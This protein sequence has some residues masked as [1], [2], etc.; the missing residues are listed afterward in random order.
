[1]A[2]DNVQNYGNHIR[3]DPIF[4]YVLAPGLLIA[5]ICGVVG[6]I[7]NPSWTGV[8]LL[9]LNV[10]AMGHFL[11]TRIYS[12][13]VQDRVIRLETRLRLERLLPEALRPRIGEFSLAQLIALRFASD[14]ELPELA[15]H[16]LDE[17]ITDGK[18]IKQ[19]VKNWQADF[20]RV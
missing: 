2:E 5:L 11:K 14:E 20:H 9:I 3:I 18:I 8:G 16:V 19:R 4:F 10:T 6:M 12:V 15:R 13:K 7:R 17:G 1:M